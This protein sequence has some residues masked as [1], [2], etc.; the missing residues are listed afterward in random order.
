ML[1]EESSFITIHNDLLPKPT[2]KQSQV[3]LAIALS[4]IDQN[5]AADETNIQQ[6]LPSNQDQEKKHNNKKPKNCLFLHY[7]YEERL[8]MLRKDIHNAY[9]QTFENSNVNRVKLM[10]AC[11]NNPKIKNE[12]IRRKRPH[13]RLRRHDFKKSTYSKPNNLPFSNSFTPLPLSLIET[14]NRG[15]STTTL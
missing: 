1:N 15:K 7:T 8:I 2:P 13:D 12:F 14:N 4:Q 3:A 9:Q 11:R 5:E 6:V 10:V